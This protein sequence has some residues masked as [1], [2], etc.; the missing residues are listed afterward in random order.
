MHERREKTG[1]TEWTRGGNTIKS[2]K[3]QNRGGDDAWGRE[4]EVEKERMEE[5]GERQVGGVESGTI[6]CIALS[7][8]SSC[9]Y[10]MTSEVPGEEGGEEGRENRGG[11]KGV[12]E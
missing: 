1:A 10:L 2:E 12:R 9:E 11:G 8:E 3:R 7:L 6:F 4:E 5:E